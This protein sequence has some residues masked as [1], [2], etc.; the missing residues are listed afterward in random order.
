MITIHGLTDRQRMLADILWNCDSTEQAYAVMH[1]L[2]G[3]DRRDA[4]ALATIMI[5][6]VLEESLSDYQDAA[7]EAIARCR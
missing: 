5:Q 1:S 2:Q 7:H 4:Q 3:Q 6:E